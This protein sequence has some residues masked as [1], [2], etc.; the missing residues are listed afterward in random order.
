MQHEILRSYPR[1]PKNFG[2]FICRWTAAAGALRC[3]ASLPSRWFW[4]L[5]AHVAAILI[6]ATWPTR[7]A[8]SFLFFSPAESHWR[9]PPLVES[10]HW[11]PPSRSPPRSAFVKQ[12]KDVATTDVRMELNFLE[13]P[14]YFL[15]DYDVP[16]S[17]PKSLS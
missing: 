5:L 6:P 9:V 7:A 3:F 15:L 12:R 8:S 10:H 11:A 2:P 4:S 1:R 17:S 14:V 16:T 13:F